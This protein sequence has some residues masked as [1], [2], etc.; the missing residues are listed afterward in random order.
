MVKGL[1]RLQDTGS[2]H[3]QKT[4]RAHKASK[5]IAGRLCIKGNPCHDGASEK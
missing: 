3:N 1:L 5:I 4:E 2:G